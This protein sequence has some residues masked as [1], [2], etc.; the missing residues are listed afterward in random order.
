MP[1]NGTKTDISTRLLDAADYME[2]FQTEN[3]VPVET[4]LD[5]IYLTLV[6][7][8]RQF[9][10]E[11]D[12]NQSVKAAIQVMDGVP[13]PPSTPSH[14]EPYGADLSGLITLC[15]PYWFDDIVAELEFDHNRPVHAAKLASLLFAMRKAEHEVQ[16]AWKTTVGAIHTAV[17]GWRGAISEA[18]EYCRG[19]A[20]MLQEGHPPA[21]SKARGKPGC[22]YETTCVEEAKARGCQAWEVAKER[23]EGHIKS[24]HPWPGRNEMASRC[25]CHPSV[26]DR[27]VQAS[28]ILQQAKAAQELQKAKPPRKP[29]SSNDTAGFMLADEALRLMIEYASDKEKAKLNTPGMREHLANMEKDNLAVLV[30]DAKQHAEKREKAIGRA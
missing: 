8:V 26:I 13:I 6:E 18:A 24:G 2:R 5:R 16:E 27:A 4:H 15:A 9:N 25:G 3:V 20:R 1:D 28:D 23:A 30:E 29:E 10:A 22:A 21:D 19:L 11:L 12:R 14:P 7:R 17:S